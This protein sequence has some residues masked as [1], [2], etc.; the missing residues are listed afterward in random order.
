MGEPPARGGYPASALAGLAELVERAGRDERGSITA[1][2]TVLTESG[3]ADP[4]AEEARAALDGHVV[5]SERLARG[6]RWPAIDL[7]AS[8]SRVMRAIAAPDHLAAAAGLRRLVAALDE[9]EE[10]ILV[11]AYRP[12]TSPETDLALA[13]REAIAAFLR[14]GSDERS[15]LAETLRRLKE[16]AQGA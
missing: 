12:G 11:G 15:P 3:A 8:V 14:Q 1:V 16:L 13:R 5:L 6:G 4:V 10:L 9:N 2:Y 7:K